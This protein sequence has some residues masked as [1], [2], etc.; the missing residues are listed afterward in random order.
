MLCP[1]ML[2]LLHISA[3]RL[4]RNH[5]IGMRNFIAIVGDPQ[6]SDLFFRCVAM[7]NFIHILFITFIQRAGNFV[8]QQ[9]ARQKL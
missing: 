1:F 9:H 8:Q 4:Q 6:N 7:N 3:G 2:Y 5:F